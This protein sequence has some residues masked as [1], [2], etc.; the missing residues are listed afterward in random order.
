[1]DTIL[2]MSCCNVGLPHGKA[3]M[4]TSGQILVTYV[5]FGLPFILPSIS[6]H[7]PPLPPPLPS[8]PPLP[9]L[10]LLLL[11]LLLHPPLSPTSLPP[12]LLSLLFL[13]PQGFG[14]DDSTLVR[15]MVSRCEVDMVQIKKKF[16]TKYYKTLG[17][18]IK[19]GEGCFFSKREPPYQVEKSSS[20]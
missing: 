5:Y 1:M 19:V 12:P 7:S 15:V 20:Q 9:P 13:F 3:G 4:S 2:Q 16:H 10:L 14:T 11:L 18:F 17:S 8:P 6:L